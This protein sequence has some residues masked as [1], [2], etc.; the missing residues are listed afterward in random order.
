MKCQERAGRL[1]GRCRSPC[2]ERGLKWSSLCRSAACLSRSPCGERGLKSSMNSILDL[3]RSRSPCGERG[4]K[5][6]TVFS[7]GR[8]SKTSLPLRGA[9]IEISHSIGLISFLVSRSPCG[10]RGLKCWH[11][12]SPTARGVSLPLRGAW[13]EILTCLNHLRCERSLPMRGAWIEIRKLPQS[14][15]TNW[16]RSPCGERGLKYQTAI[17][18][19]PSRMSLP[20]V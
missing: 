2:G 1:A 10:E 18:I 16:G 8:R 20:L 17:R 9:W 6:K 4:L 19:H 13:I 14:R 3:K 15:K 12:A 11:C 7:R 5:C